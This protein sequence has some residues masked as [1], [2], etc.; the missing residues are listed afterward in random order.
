MNI[1]FCKKANKNNKINH[2]IFIVKVKFRFRNNQLLIISYFFL[3]VNSVCIMKLHTFEISSLI[4]MLSSFS[5]II[6]LKIKSRNFTG[7]NITEENEIVAN[8]I[9]YL[10]QSHHF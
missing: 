3:N 2:K 7:Y 5:F 9:Q 8:C 4:I 1:F 10:Y 6:S